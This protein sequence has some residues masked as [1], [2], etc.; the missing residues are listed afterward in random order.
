MHNA[1]HTPITNLTTPFPDL[2]RGGCERPA[3]VL[4]PSPGGK[5]D[6]TTETAAAA[7]S[8]TYPAA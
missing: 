1:V 8:G 3:S 4:L 7:T 5:I 6:G 2:T